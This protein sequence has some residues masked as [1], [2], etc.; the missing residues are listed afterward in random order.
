MK[1]KRSAWHCKISNFGGNY[2]RGYGREDDNLCCYFWRI[3]GKLGMLT[4]IICVVGLLAYAYF[5]SIFVIPTTIMCL[6]ILSVIIIPTL[7]IHYIREKKGEPITLPGENILYEYL[8]A[9][10]R[11]VCPLI[12]YI[13]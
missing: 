6:F 3:V 8:K 1:V 5:T 11:K 9:K 10:K 12:E 2:P 7:A 13:D 4:F